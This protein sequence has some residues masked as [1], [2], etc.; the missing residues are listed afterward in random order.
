MITT[1]TSISIGSMGKSKVK[2]TMA[3][4]DPPLMGL[5]SSAIVTIGLLQELMATIATCIG[6]IFW[7]TL[8]I[9]TSTSLL[10]TWSYL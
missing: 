7:K 3:S 9:G 4:F 8:V 1:I 6:E 10:V 2:E 5:G